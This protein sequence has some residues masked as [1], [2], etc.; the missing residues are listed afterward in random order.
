MA[1]PQLPPSADDEQNPKRFQVQ[2][3]WQLLTWVIAPL[4]I[5]IAGVG[6]AKVSVICYEI[7]S[8]IIARAGFGSLVY[9]PI[10]YALLIYA[11]RKFFPGTGGSGI[12]QAIAV[13]ADYD[14]RK[15]SNLL[16]LRIVV[17]RVLLLIG[18]LIIGASV[19]HEGPMVQIGGSLM[20]AFFGYSTLKTA[21]QRQVLVLAGGAAGVAATFNAPLGGM[22]FAMEE[23]A[24]K[25][26]F[27]GHNRM[28]LTVLLSGLV[29]LLIMGSYTY[30]GRY[31]I[32]MAFWTHVPAIIVCGVVG[33]VFG[34][35]FSLAAQKTPDALPTNLRRMLVHHPMAFAA[36]CG[37]IVA[38]LSLATDGAINGTGYV[39]TKMALESDAPTH[40]WFYGLSKFIATLLSALSG[41]PGG[42]FAPTLSVGGGLGDLVSHILPDLAPH[43]AL[44]I[45]VMV[46]YLAGLTQ[47]PL[48]AFMVTM[49]ITG[50][51]ELLM[52]MIAVSLIANFVSLL[53]CPTSFYHK[54][55]LRF[56][57]KPECKAETSSSAS[58][59]GHQAS[60]READVV[61]SAQQGSVAPTQQ[62]VAVDGDFV[63]PD[64]EKRDD[65][66]GSA[67]GTS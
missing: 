53:V 43:K 37:L 54:L 15:K 46:A 17:G 18:G 31:H 4:L 14:G 26:V 51:Y 41:L 25:Y 9:M 49:E 59:E 47:S 39:P 13:L 7:N 61:P 55:A 12:P 8:W 27:K 52:P 34:G 64:G 28:I 66:N 36:I 50:S 58:D 1:S 60:S 6:M 67:G 48:T 3:V 21:E 29:S 22:M 10:G 45:L 30:F 19:G 65:V 33:G 40:V 63:K 56:E 38:C 24:K 44:I 23:M 2:S 35:L 62:R 11:S 16:S 32:D 5:G 42:L 57:K 20:H